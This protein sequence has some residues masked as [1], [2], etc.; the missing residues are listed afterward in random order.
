MP[1]NRSNYPPNWEE[2]S[3]AEREAASNRCRRCQ[4]PNGSLVARN[5]AD[6]EEWAA[7]VVE[8]DCW[9]YSDD[10]TTPIQVDAPDR[11]GDL[12]KVVLTVGHVDQNPQNNHP[13]NLRA[14]CQRCHL[15]HDRPYNIEKQKRKRA[16]RSGQLALNM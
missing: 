1:M 7:Y 9:Y 8:E 12:I 6:K 11:W 2:I 10:P 3:L 14:W 13:D 15:N 16:I 5:P 4:V